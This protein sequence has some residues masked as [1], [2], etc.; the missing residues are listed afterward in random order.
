[1]WARKHKKKMR[2]RQGKGGRRYECNTEEKALEREAIMIK[3]LSEKISV[4]IH[5]NVNES[6]HTHACE[7]KNTIHRQKHQLC[8]L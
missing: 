8:V 4:H 1:V 6:T 7:H 5:V 3:S 2:G